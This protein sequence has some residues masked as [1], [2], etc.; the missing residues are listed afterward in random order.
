MADLMCATAT[1]CSNIALIKYW[2]KAD[3]DL[4]LPL[5]GSVSMTLSEALTTT[6]VQW[7]SA[8]AGDELYM[9]GE[10]VL[11]G[12]LTRVSRFLD[13][14]RHEWYRLPARVAT[15]SSFPAGT[16]IAS[17]ASGFAALA[18]AGIAAFGEGL[19]EPGELSRWARR[20]SGSA[21]RSIHGGFVEWLA[22]DDES[23]RARQLCGP[24]H[25]DLRDLVVIV[26]G[27]PKELSSS[28]GHR[29]ASRHPFMPARQRLLPARTVALKGALVGRDFDTLGALVEQEALEMH[30]VMISGEPAGLYLQPA[31]VALLHAV[32]RWRAD[33]LPV[34]ATLDAG[35]NVHLLVEGR[36]A[37]QL[38]SALAEQAPGL[39]VL[40]NRPGPP[41][42]LSEHHLI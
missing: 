35:P 10:R 31:T 28:E 36:H 27:D 12:R 20:G 14:L 30:G 2:G 25:W 9:A 3:F 23:S 7:D 37:A 40:H 1:A 41:V 29:V 21:C 11:D 13:R 32:R 16:G 8:L 22:G 15:V 5:N 38:E 6:T 17:S 39:R 26:S 33:G 34:Y 19:P 4:N 18:T 24:E 42:T